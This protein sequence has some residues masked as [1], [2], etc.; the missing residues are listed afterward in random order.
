M[1]GGGLHY[2]LSRILL[3]GVKHDKAD[4][5]EKD[6][7]VISSKSLACVCMEL[8]VHHM[9]KMN[10]CRCL[11]QAVS[12]YMYIHI[13]VVLVLKAGWALTSRD[14]YMFKY[15]SVW[16]WCSTYICRSVSPF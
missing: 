9:H 16:V 5:L 15:W 14:Y 7:A 1:R 4:D 6:G 12:I 11:L 10:P 3:T 8:S 13:K 2:W